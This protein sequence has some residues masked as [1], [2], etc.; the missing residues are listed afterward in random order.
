MYFNHRSFVR[1]LQLA[2]SERPIHVRRALYLIVFTFLY[3]AF[4]G[5]VLIVR[6]LDQWFWPGVKETPIVAPVFIIAPPRSGTSFLQKIMTRDETR[7]V[8]W[9][10]YQTILPTVL[11]EK[12]IAGMLGIDRALGRPLSRLLGWCEKQ[13]FGGWDNLHTMRLDAPEEDGALYLYAF[14]CE[15]IY[16]LFPYV[17][18]LW[19]LGFPDTLPLA[20]RRALL[21]YYRT[22]LQRLVFA[23]GQGKT[24]LIKSTNSCG[25][26]EAI[27]EEFPD[28]RFITIMRDPATSITSSISLMMPAI[29]AHSPETPSDGP[30]SK[31]YARLSVEWYKYLNDFKARLP[32]EQIYTVDYRNLVRDP[33]ATVE[34]IYRHFDWTVSEAF[35]ESLQKQKDAQKEFKSGHRY[36]LEEFG[37]DRAWVYRELEGVLKAN[38]YPHQT[39]SASADAESKQGHVKEA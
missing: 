19:E 3:L 11:T 21:R 1:A 26:V 18:E 25:A 37:V 38:G 24:L 36:S 20:D 34:E 33:K 22:C 17:D 15:A 12:L 2:L 29:K 31:S 10:M 13:W 27:L 35:S 23:G 14:A 39:A 28:A 5:L 4:V 16:M 30:L 7:F 6:K 8:F 32:A 9:K